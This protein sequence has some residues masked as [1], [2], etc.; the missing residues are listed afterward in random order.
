MCQDEFAPEHVVTE[1]DRG[2]TRG[3]ELREL[4]AEEHKCENF[5]KNR[6]K[7]SQQHGPKGNSRIE[8]SFPLI[9]SVL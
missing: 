6:H 2:G 7:K 3:E 5:D 9:R 1:P 4:S 8:L